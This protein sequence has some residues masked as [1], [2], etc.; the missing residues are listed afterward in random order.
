MAKQAQST[1][2][3]IATQSSLKTIVDWSNNT[4]IKLNLKELVAITNVIVDYIEFGYSA[5]IGV[6]LENIQSYIDE[7]K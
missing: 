4:G 1:Q 5:E 2:K 3:Q 6:R 7:E